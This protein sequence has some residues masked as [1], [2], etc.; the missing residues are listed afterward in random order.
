MHA[1]TSPGHQGKRRPASADRAHLALAFAGGQQVGDYVTPV[2]AANS[3]S[4]L[5]L[6]ERL[7][8]AYLYGPPPHRLRALPGSAS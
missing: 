3:R 4:V 7:V 5:E 2:Q 1:N 6:Y 8:D